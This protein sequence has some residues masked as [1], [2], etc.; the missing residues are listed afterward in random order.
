MI[1]TSDWLLS[2][3]A[4]LF[5]L[6]AA[7]IFIFVPETP[8]PTYHYFRTQDLPA[9]LIILPVI[10]LAAIWWPKPGLPDRMPS[11]PSVVIVAVLLALVLWAA[12]YS[13]MLA[14]PLTRDEHMAV[15]DA[16]IYSSGELAAPLDPEWREFAYAL[17]PNF[18]LD[19]PGN[20]LLV[21]S[22]MPGN[23]MMRA[24]F[25][26]VADPAL[27]NPAL[28]AI[29]LI[30]LYDVARHLFSSSPAAVWVVLATYLLSAQVLVNA[31]TSYAM[32]GH[33]ALNL[34]W[35][36]FFLRGKWWQHAIAMA[37]GAWTIG[38]HQVVFH[39]LFAGPFILMLLSQRRRALFAAYSLVYV[40]ALLFWLSYPSMVVAS[41]GVTSQGGSTGGIVAFLL[42]RVWPL[43]SRNSLSSIAIMEFNMLRLMVWTP[44]FVLPLLVLAWP[45]IRRIKSPALPLFGGVILTILAMAILLPYQGHGWGYRYLHGLIG[46]L[47]LLSGFGYRHWAKSD[48]KRADGTI[49]FLGGAG[50]F[51]LLPFLLWSAYGFTAPYARLSAAIEQQPSDFVIIDTETSLAAIDQVRNRSDL[52]NR[53]LVLSS[54]S[55][56]NARLAELC[57]KGSLTL[58]G[59]SNIIAAN[60]PMGA[61][62]A[63]NSPRALAEA[64][65]PCVRPFDWQGR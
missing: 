14:Y 31:M 62:A 58:L 61:A 26:A 30:A 50:A 3:T 22:Y 43:L 7:T 20:G 49:A 38:L 32:T 27:M 59:P 39:P 64:L 10:A 2:R 16:Q 11:T 23:A 29:G 13:V 44:L 8:G 18:L 60:L 17:V 48:R 54:I 55:L 47:A 1:Q 4:G 65:G 37:I 45:D 36:A 25:S 41:F 34:V 53:P 9:T 57:E 33:L 19:A 63:T 35:L 21:S 12:T 28:C 15:F 42:E 52:A 51:I 40:T 6:L 46:N 24:G 56:S 5:A